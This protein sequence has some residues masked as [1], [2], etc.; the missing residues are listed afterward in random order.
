MA[1]GRTVADFASEAAPVMV[2]R[3]LSLKASLLRPFKVKTMKRE[4]AET[5]ARRAEMA[6]A[7][8]AASL[9]QAGER[10][11]AARESTAAAYKLAVLRWEGERIV[12]RRLA[13][14]VLLDRRLQAR[15]FG[16]PPSGYVWGEVSPT[17]TRQLI[18]RGR[19]LLEA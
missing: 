14:E 19:A 16:A 2:S 18:A 5:I 1:C 15:R 17:D 12:A 6:V 13:M 3:F 10:S 11:I 7:L 9:K 4:G 8:K